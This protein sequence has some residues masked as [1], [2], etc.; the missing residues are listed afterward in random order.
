[1]KVLYF[2][3]KKN[4]LQMYEHF[5]FVSQKK[6]YKKTKLSLVTGFPNSLEKFVGS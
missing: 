4:L 3:L 1:M 5:V 6:S 2:W